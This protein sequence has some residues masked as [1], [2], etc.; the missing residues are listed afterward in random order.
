MTESTVD[1][2]THLRDRSGQ[3]DMPHQ[4]RNSITDV[5]AALVAKE[6]PHIVL[7]SGEI[8]PRTTYRPQLTTFDNESESEYSIDEDVSPVLGRASSVR[9]SKPQIVRH[10]SS[11]NARK[12]KLQ[13]QGLARSDSHSLAKVERISRLQPDMLLITPEESARR[14]S[15]DDTCLIPPKDSNT[16]QPTTVSPQPTGSATL[17]PPTNKRGLDAP[18]HDEIDFAHPPPTGNT[19][20][21]IQSVH[22]TIVNPDTPSIDKA[23]VLNDA[24]VVP[25]RGLN[26]AF[27]AP[28]PTP[29]GSSR[30]VTIR[31]AN[32]IINHQNPTTSFRESIVTTPYPQRRASDQMSVDFVSNFDDKNLNSNSDDTKEAKESEDKVLRAVSFNQSFEVNNASRRNSGKDRFPSP[33]R[34]EVLFIDLSLLNHPSARTTIEIQVTDKGTFDDELLFQQIRTAYSRQLLGLPRL[35]L[36]LVRNVGYA[37]V[38]SPL[39]YDAT[40][41]NNIGFTQHF[42]NPRRGR[43]RKAWVIWLRNNNPRYA[44]SV[45]AIPTTAVKNSDTNH[46]SSNGTP[47]RQIDNLNR[48][49]LRT[50]PLFSSAH[51]SRTSSRNK[52]LHTDRDINNID[53]TKRFSTASD[54]SSFNFVYSPAIPRLPFLNS[55]HENQPALS[56][57]HANSPVTF[58]AAAAAAL[59]GSGSPC[60]SFFWPSSFSSTSHFRG[61]G[62]NQDSENE[63]KVLTV[64]FHHQ[65][66]VGMIAALTVLNVLFAVLAA[67]IWVVFG[68]PGTRPGMSGHVDE[69]LGQYDGSGY[70]EADARARVLTGVV[71]GIVVLLTGTL[72]EGGL[73]WG[74]RV[75]L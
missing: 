22:P 67:T 38:T 44:A 1:N 74:A 24:E 18:T 29:R 31:A 61:T 10:K 51:H 23:Q 34:P 53:P 66:R 46:I 14:P 27:S 39:N 21:T 33:K 41:F 65:Y 54:A 35:L 42:H 55:R 37:T 9:V 56:A 8:L 7:D 45:T 20:N 68:V 62:S 72:I 75:L 19:T 57:S 6:R 30:R 71:V 32:L 5:P 64:S 50:H 49:S 47:V 26:R 25:E 12:S 11:F 13:G 58:A 73:V 36:T 15:S 60:R 48:L 17:P 4:K 43:K 3:D 52:S 40:E 2:E 70:W 28:L 59:P 69:R 16:E 63:V